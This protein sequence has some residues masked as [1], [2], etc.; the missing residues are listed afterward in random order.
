MGCV[1]KGFKEFI[2]RG[3]VVDLAVG[4]VIGVAFGAMVTQFTKSF[5]E[6][7]IEVITGGHDTGGKF[8]I[9]EVDFDY[10]AFIGSVIS[11]VL[12]AL[13]VYYFVVVP[14]NA[15]AKRRGKTSDDESDEV[16]LLTEIRD[17]LP[18]ER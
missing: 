16:K 12:T 15:W 3:S 7:L 18:A 8:T 6:P 9:N 17:R 1:F 4:I 10:G 13:A 11:F 5:L 2:A 14:M